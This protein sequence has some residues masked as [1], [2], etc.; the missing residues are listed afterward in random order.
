M[1]GADTVIRELIRTSV[2]NIYDSYFT[3]TNTQTD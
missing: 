3:E 1:R 2:A